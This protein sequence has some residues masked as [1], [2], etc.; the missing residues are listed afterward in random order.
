MLAVFAWHHPPP[1]EQWGESD[2]TSIIF[3]CNFNFPKMNWGITVY[4][5]TKSNN[6]KEEG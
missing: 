5:G 3:C 2:E 1:P 4:A 6:H